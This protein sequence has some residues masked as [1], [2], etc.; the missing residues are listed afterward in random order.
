VLPRDIPR[1]RPAL[2]INRFASLVYKQEDKKINPMYFGFSHLTMRVKHV[3]YFYRN[4]AR[5][6]VE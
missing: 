6:W 5:P 4:L 3:E 2:G 1:W